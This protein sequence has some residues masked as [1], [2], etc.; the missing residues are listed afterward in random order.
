MSTL[1]MENEKIYEI[2]LFLIFH[3]IRLLLL[4]MKTGIVVNFIGVFMIT[5]ATNTW[6]MLIF[7]FDSIPENWNINNPAKRVKRIDFWGDF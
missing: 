1:S 5:I 3:C 7:N 2:F 4:Q 6:G